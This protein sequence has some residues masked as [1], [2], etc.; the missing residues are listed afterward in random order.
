MNELDIQEICF[1][2]WLWLLPLMAGIRDHIFE[3]RF[4]KIGRF[5]KTG[6]VQY[7]NY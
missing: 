4:I 6:A 1:A 3:Y 7:F 5:R 2:R